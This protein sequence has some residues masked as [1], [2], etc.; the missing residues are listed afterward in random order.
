MKGKEEEKGQKG[1]E[2]RGKGK[3]RRR[4]RTTVNKK[5]LTG[6]RVPPFHR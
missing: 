2:G 1:K 4:E 3:G 6:L 5:L